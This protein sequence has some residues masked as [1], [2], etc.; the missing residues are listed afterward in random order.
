MES[1][2]EPQFRTKCR[3]MG[4]FMWKRHQR[5]PRKT[6]TMIP[7]ALKH[8][9]LHLF[10]CLLSS[11]TSV[12][13]NEVMASNSATAADSSRIPMTGLNSTPSQTGWHQRLLS[14]TDN[15]FQSWQVDHSCKH[16]DSCKRLPHHLGRCEDSSQGA[17]HANFKPSGK[18]ER[19]AG[20]FSCSCRSGD[21]PGNRLQIMVTLVFRMVPE[22]LYSAGNIQC[23][24]I[25]WACGTADETI[26]TGS[27][28]AFPILQILLVTIRN[29]WSKWKQLRSWSGRIK[30]FWKYR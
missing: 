12:V 11:N 14:L 18:A 28:T 19:T 29:E 20:C 10:Y 23:K 5:I 17:Y 22:I 25:I 16:C 9:V 8:N 4:C 24:I 2:R 30:V 15:Y 6:V 13:I 1:T 21:I 3:I 26:A 7:K 27:M